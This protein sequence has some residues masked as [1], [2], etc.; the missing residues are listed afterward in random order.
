M[1]LANPR[2]IIKK[3]STLVIYHRF[4]PFLAMV[5]RCFKINYSCFGV[6]LACFQVLELFGEKWWFWCL[7][8]IKWERPVADHQTVQRSMIEDDNRSTDTLCCRSTA[9]C[10]KTRLGS[11][12]LK[13]QVSQELPNCSWWVLT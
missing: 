2:K 7:L 4:Y 3:F 10:A 1:F 9:N 12:Q 8:E 5:Y 6:F 13:A 11:S